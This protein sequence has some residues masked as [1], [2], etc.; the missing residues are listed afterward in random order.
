V[1]IFADR[2]GV[3]STTQ[4]AIEECLDALRDDI[5]PLEVE[6]YAWNVLPRSLI[7]LELSEG[8]SREM[9]WLR[10]LIQMRERGQP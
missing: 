4:G 1:P 5:P 7:T 10:A 6:T 2:L 8:I 3:I 9:E